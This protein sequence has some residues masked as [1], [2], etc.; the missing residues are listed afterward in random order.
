M[1]PCTGALGGK[2]KEEDWQ[3]ML[4]Q[5]KSFPEKKE[6]I[7]SLFYSDSGIM[8]IFI[9]SPYLLEALTVELI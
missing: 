7:D 3:Q 9:K 6:I 4:T 8:I 2:K 5:G 1:Q